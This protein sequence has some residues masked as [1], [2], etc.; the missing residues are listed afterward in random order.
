M[1]LKG[2]DN[3]AAGARPVRH[4]PYG[5]PRT[6]LAG[7]KATRREDLVALRNAIV[8]PTGASSS[9]WVEW[10]WTRRESSGSA[11]P[12]PP[13]S[14]DALPAFRWSRLDLHIG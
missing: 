3:L 6:T 5:L 14:D 2:P 13:E 8:V 9:W 7:L 1:G 11:L 4:S 10:T 12:G